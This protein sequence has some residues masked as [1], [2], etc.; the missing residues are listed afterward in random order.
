MLTQVYIF[1]RYLVISQCLL[2]KYRD[3]VFNNTAHPYG[4]IRYNA[5][6]D[7]RLN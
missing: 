5:D 6:K 1:S 2:S 4:I 7:D 3:K